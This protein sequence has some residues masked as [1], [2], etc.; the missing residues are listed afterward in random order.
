MHNKNQKK[1][2][3]TKTISFATRKGGSGKTTLTILTATALYHRSDYKI[4]VID[5]DHQLSL[6]G[7]Y[8]REKGDNQNYDA[9]GF[10]WSHPRARERFVKLIIENE[11]KYDVVFIDTSGKLEGNDIYES[12]IASDIIIVPVVAA[13][14]DMFSSADFLQ[15]IPAVIKKRKM[16]GFS[17][18]VFGVPNL[19][20]NT[21]EQGGIHEIEEIKESGIKLFENGVSR[22]VRYKRLSTIKQIVKPEKE[23]DEFNLYFNEFLTLC[24]L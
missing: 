6:Y 21:K 4:L 24:K 3:E 5:N 18:K 2:M 8:K 13:E 1:K 11:E 10:D 9:I 12:M 14:L 23:D 20:D 15:S 7:K 17:T 19:V 22:R 16:L